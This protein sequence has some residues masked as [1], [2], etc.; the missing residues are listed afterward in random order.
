MNVLLMLPNLRLK[1][2][3]Q[4]WALTVVLGYC[5][6]RAK[7]TPTLAWVRFTRKKVH[8]IIFFAKHEVLRILLMT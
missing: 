1:L 5:K 6:A 8:L 7:A 2:P 3:V 4:I